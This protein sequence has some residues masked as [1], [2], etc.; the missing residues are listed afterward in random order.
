GPGAARARDP[1]ADPGRRGPAV[2]RT[3][4]RHRRPVAGPGGLCAARPGD[5]CAEHVRQDGRTRV[6]ETEGGPVDAATPRDSV[7][8]DPQAYRRAIGRFA[9]G[10]TVATTFAG[11]HDHAM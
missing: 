10:V 8:V 5:R 6:M 3:V 1:G 7:P 9:T 4:Q 11:R 2:L